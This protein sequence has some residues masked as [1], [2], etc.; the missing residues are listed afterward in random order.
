MRRVLVHLGHRHL[1]GAPKPFDL[2]PVDFFGAGP[3]LGT[4]QDTIGQ[5][6]RL[7]SEPDRR[8]S[9]WIRRISLM[10]CSKV[11]AIA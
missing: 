5:R 4:A 2:V 7:I 9:C 3:S 1:M 6:G 10:Q 11:A 8:A